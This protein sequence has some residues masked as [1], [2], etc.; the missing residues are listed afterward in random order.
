MANRRLTQAEL[1]QANAL[2]L[3]IRRKLEKLAGADK[4]LMFAFRRKVYKELT[5]D[6]RSKPAVRVRL[7][8]EKRKDQLG[9]CAICQQAL[10]A[11]YAVL[12]RL[13]AVD[14]YTKLNTRLIHEECDVRTQELRRYK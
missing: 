6:E 11:K 8:A 9:L 14:G 4:E 3:S 13:N 10:P 1:K 2:L 12:D 7:K 5:Y